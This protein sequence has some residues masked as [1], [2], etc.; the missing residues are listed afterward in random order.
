MYVINKVYCKYGL[1]HPLHRSE[2]SHYWTLYKI[3]M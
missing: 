1:P 2:S 3:G